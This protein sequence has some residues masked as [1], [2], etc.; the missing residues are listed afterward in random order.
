VPAREAQDSQWRGHSVCYDFPGLR[1]LLR[2][3]ED[4]PISVSRSKYLLLPFA[5]VTVSFVAVTLANVYLNYGIDWWYETLLANQNKPAGQFGSTGPVGSNPGG[6]A[7]AEQHVL[8]GDNDM[9]D[10]G[11]T[12]FGYTVH[13]TNGSAYDG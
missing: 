10:D 3:L 2:G 13:T 1:E 8:S 7:N 4:L 11:N 12:A 9:A 5:P 6:P